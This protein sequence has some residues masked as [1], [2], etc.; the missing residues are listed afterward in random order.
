MK[1][2]YIKA[3]NGQM[4]WK[5]IETRNNQVFMRMKKRPLVSVTI[6]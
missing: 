4:I 3:K 5:Q 6:Q 1:L 2:N